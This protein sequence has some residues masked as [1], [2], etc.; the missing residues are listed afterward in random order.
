MKLDHFE[1]IHYYDWLRQHLVDFLQSL[2]V[3]GSEPGGY[4]GLGL[5]GA[6]GDKMRCYN[7][8]WARGGLHPFH[9]AA[10][11]LLSYV[12]P[13][14]QEVWADDANRTLIKDVDEW[15]LENAGRFLPHLP[16][17][18]G[19]PGCPDCAGTGKLKVCPD[20]QAGEGHP[21]CA[22]DHEFFCECGLRRPKLA[23]LW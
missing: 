18:P 6:H 10:I 20:C 8:I 16:A 1:K 9:G 7:R 2:K 12:R 22:N 23:P 21:E 5:I 13:Y 15:V 17:V 11:F 3:P 14:K 4:V 19:V